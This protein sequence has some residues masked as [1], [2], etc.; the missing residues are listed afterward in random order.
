MLASRRLDRK[1]LISMFRIYCR[2]MKHERSSG[3]GGKL[4]SS[5]SELL[6]YSLDKTAKCQWKKEGR[7]CSS[8]PVHCF[9][10]EE[11]ERI[12]VVMRFSGPRLMLSHP[13]FAIRYLIM[14]AFN[15]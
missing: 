15:H 12:K 11:R 7:L 3:E 4:C 5:C 13:L 9:E 8:C 1:T 14:K 2:A 6:N 10:P